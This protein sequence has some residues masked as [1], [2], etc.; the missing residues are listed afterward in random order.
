M[1]ATTLP[2][3]LKMMTLAFWLCVQ[4][5]STTSHAGRG[6][7]G[8]PGMCNLPCDSGSCNN[9]LVWASSMADC[10]DLS[11]K[12]GCGD[13]KASIPA[14]IEPYAESYGGNYATLCPPG[15]Q[16]AYS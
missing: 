9:W 14:G 8:C 5:P 13:C 6:E 11:Q 2:K 3:Q 15:A 7:P 4:H 1:G 16:P 10:N 12:M